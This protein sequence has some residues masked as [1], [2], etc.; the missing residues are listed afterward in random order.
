VLKNLDHGV[1]RSTVAKVLKANGIPP[2]PLRLSS[3]GTFLR[4]H[5]GAIAEADFFT[6]EIWTPRGLVTHLITPA[7]PTAGGA[8]VRYRQRLGGLLRYYHRAA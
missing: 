5:W 2:A 1:A 3:R 7:V 6:S 4:A 8:Q